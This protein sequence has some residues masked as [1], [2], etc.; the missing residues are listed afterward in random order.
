MIRTLLLAV[1][2][3]LTVGVQTVKAGGD[4]PFPWGTESAFQWK[5]IEGCWQNDH[6]KDVIFDFKV[7]RETASGTKYLKVE[8]IDSRTADFIEGVA[9]ARKDDKIVRARVQGE[10]GE[11]FMLIRNYLQKDVGGRSKNVTYLT[12]RQLDNNPKNDMHY[13]LNKVSGCQ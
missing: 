4:K 7:I 9:V 1:A 5:Q 6:L 11:F 2:L 8:I 3:F 12:V 10:T 13:L